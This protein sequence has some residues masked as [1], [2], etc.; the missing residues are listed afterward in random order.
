MLCRILSSHASLLKLCGNHP[1]QSCGFLLQEEIDYTMDMHMAGAFAWTVHFNIKLWPQILV[2]SSVVM[3][4]AKY[5]PG[6]NNM[7]NH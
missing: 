1:R 3:D 5:P 2:A 4:I 6:I 7:V